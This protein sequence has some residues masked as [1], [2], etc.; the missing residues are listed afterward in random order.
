MA[1]MRYA[2]LLCALFACGCVGTES[3]A[4]NAGGTLAISTGGDP[5]VLI[6][7]LLQSVQAAQIADMVYDRLAD[8]GDSLNI[9][10][11]KVFTPRLRDHSISS[12][13]SLSVPSHISP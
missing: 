8:V 7:S 5:D 2:G 1:A 10:N 11:G 12:L 4:G 3:S 9:L 13:D 6:P